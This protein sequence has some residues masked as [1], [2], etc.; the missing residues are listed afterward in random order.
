MT[1][2]QGSSNPVSFTP[3]PNQVINNYDI[4]TPRFDIEC[5]MTTR[6]WTWRVTLK[7]MPNES[8]ASAFLADAIAL[9]TQQM[10]KQ[11]GEKR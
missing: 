8:T 11:V 2:E 9:V 6:G 7:D 10:E 1:G 5:G 4:P 3:M